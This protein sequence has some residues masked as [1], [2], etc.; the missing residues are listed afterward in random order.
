MIASECQ[1]S[2]GIKTQLHIPVPISHNYNNNNF[3]VLFCNIFATLSFC[4]CITRQDLKRH[5]YSHRK[6]EVKRNYKNGRMPSGGIP[7][8]KR[9]LQSMQDHVDN[10]TRTNS[11]I[12]PE[13]PSSET[14]QEQRHN[15]VN[16]TPAEIRHRLSTDTYD[17]KSLI[18][19]C[20]ICHLALSTKYHLIDH[21]RKHER[22]SALDYVAERPLACIY[23]NCY[24]RYKTEE[25][26]A[27]HYQLVHLKV[28][29]LHCK[30][31][32]RGYN[33]EHA[34]NRHMEREHPTDSQKKERT[35]TVCDIVSKS[36]SLFDNHM[37]T[38]EPLHDALR[39]QGKCKCEDNSSVSVQK[40]IL[41][42][43]ED[44][45]RHEYDM[46]N[47]EKRGKTC[48]ICNK[49]YGSWKI[50]LNHMELHNPLHNIIRENE[51]C[52]CKDNTVWSVQQCIISNRGY[53]CSLEHD[54]C[55]CK[56]CRAYREYD[57]R[58]DDSI[59]EDRMKQ[60]R[61]NS[62]SAQKDSTTQG[63][64]NSDSVQN[65]A[66]GAKENA[67]AQDSLKTKKR[68]K[69]VTVLLPSNMETVKDKS[70]ISKQVLKLIKENKVTRQ[71]KKDNSTRMIL[72][73][74]G[75]TSSNVSTHKDSEPGDTNDSA[76]TQRHSDPVGTDIGG[77][78]Q[79]QSEEIVTN[80]NLSTK[81]DSRPQGTNNDSIQK[82]SDAGS[83]FHNVVQGENNSSLI[84]KNTTRLFQMN[85]SF[86]RDHTYSV[87]HCLKRGLRRLSEQVITEGKRGVKRGKYK[88][89]KGPMSKGNVYIRPIE[90]QGA[91]I[92]RQLSLTTNRLPTKNAAHMVQG[93]VHIHT[94]EE[95]VV[96][97]MS[98]GNST[99]VHGAE[100]T[101]NAPQNDT[102]PTQANTSNVEE[103]GVDILKDAI[104]YAVD[105]AKDKTV[106]NPQENSNKDPGKGN[107]RRKIV[108]ALPPGRMQAVKDKSGISKQV[109]KL[110][111]E[112]KITGQ[113]HKGP[114]TIVPVNEQGGD[115]M[116]IVKTVIPPQL[117]EE[118]HISPSPRISIVPGMP[119]IGIAPDAPGMPNII[120]I[121]TCPCHD[122][123]GKG[124]LS[125]KILPKSRENKMQQCK[126]VTPS[127]SLT[128]RHQGESVTP[129]HQGESVTQP[130]QGESVT[131]PQQG[132]SV[133]PPQ[134]GESVTPPQQGESVTPP[135]QGES[136]TPPQQGESVTPSQ[137][138]D[139]GILSQPDVSVTLPQQ[140]KSVT[141][142][143]Q[144][145]TVTPPQL[146]ESV[147]S[148]QQDGTYTGKT[149]NIEQGNDKR[150]TSGNQCDTGNHLHER[151]NPHGLNHSHPYICHKY[152]SQ[153]E[154]P[155]EGPN[156]GQQGQS[157]VKGSNIKSITSRILPQD[158]RHAKES[159]NVVA[160]FTLGSKICKEALKRPAGPL[161]RGQPGPLKFIR[162]E[163]CQAKGS[164]SMVI[165]V[166]KSVLPKRIVKKVG[167]KW[168]PF[169]KK[170]NTCSPVGELHQDTRSQHSGELSITPS[171]VKSHVTIPKETS[172]KTLEGMG[173]SLST[174]P[175]EQQR[176]V[177]MPEGV[178]E[179]TVEIVKSKVESHT[180]NL[181]DITEGH[182]TGGIVS[183][184]P[185][186]CPGKQTGY[187]P[188]R[189]GKNAIAR[190]VIRRTIIPVRPVS[191]VN[192]DSQGT[193][194][195]EQRQ[196]LSKRYSGSV[197]PMRYASVS[198]KTLLPVLVTKRNGTQ[199]GPNSG[200]KGYVKVQTQAK[201]SENNVTNSPSSMTDIPVQIPVT[202]NTQSRMNSKQY[203]YEQSQALANPPE[204]NSTNQPPVKKVFLVPVINITPQRNSNEVENE[205][206][207]E[208]EGT[209]PTLYVT[210]DGTTNESASVP[211]GIVINI[212]P[213][214]SS[215]QE[216]RPCSPLII[217]PEYSK[218]AIF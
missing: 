96:I 116:K 16:L 185:V 94:T 59:E 159:K 30:F 26:L 164:K 92:E 106:S 44:P 11:S 175:K 204:N 198:S 157:N 24:Y 88:K 56:E 125:R 149:L 55:D 126:S 194:N 147:T 97:D 48:S 152:S 65:D 4:R 67:T 102:G 66:P 42:N 215:N 137:Q 150:N 111:K 210:R 212:P 32:E 136:G 174:S 178:K 61:N 72:H 160:R 184:V 60:A 180:G 207:S 122:R 142:N 195:S 17:Y 191:M 127:K 52:Q 167:D 117:L 37:K 80:N 148:P 1:F 115:G 182:D 84:D 10:L 118:E 21:L 62:D 141:A 145:E 104:L 79:V 68:M 158:Q 110:I 38:H 201:P 50:L 35:C 46:K 77:S 53:C 166:P 71:F 99:E 13:N 47:L 6:H 169:E 143:Q 163:Q 114:F 107:S 190:K 138:E 188:P 135:Q 192:K 209:P 197:V 103:E 19:T 139:S 109:L 218:G 15:A 113:F 181:D 33:K 23:P 90:E 63:T 208:P 70:G 217:M 98:Q 205:C 85:Y 140:G 83:D 202:N 161:D 27:Q 22:Q 8:Y 129:R 130:Q 76:S 95:Q 151:N 173:D 49:V 216:T 78:T 119:S 112:N 186:K 165:M 64:S 36:K 43:G 86:I 123:V 187:L 81:K 20:K 45:K 101:V 162:Q 156:K 177:Q 211:G 57:A 193:R 93:D 74:K 171:P 176:S 132:E 14:Q 5:E 131:P 29:K 2:V 120:H 91:N 9:I 82:D 133:T 128:P 73:G 155:A 213:E 154:T 18:L 153:S 168:I 41:A 28:Y 7:W 75:S 124:N 100:E 200:Q 3:S 58:T 51:K 34:L 144:S 203:R 199:Q 54:E 214:P 39:Q 25:G 12:V 87:G 105:T 172:Q 69:I 89:T 121:R 108:V 146:G 170:Q 206:A 189:D 179:E 40:C 134:Q 183:I 196:L 31:C